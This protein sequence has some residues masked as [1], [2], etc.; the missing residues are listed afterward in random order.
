MRVDLDHLPPIRPVRWIIL[1][2]LC[3]A[4][5]LIIGKFAGNRAADYVATAYDDRPPP[6]RP[7][8]VKNRPATHPT[9]GR[10]V[11]S[12]TIIDDHAGNCAWI[13]IPNN[14][15]VIAPTPTC[16]VNYLE[17]PEDSTQPFHVGNPAKSNQSLTVSNNTFVYVSQH[18]NAQGYR[19]TDL[20]YA[21]KFYN[22]AF[23][24]D[25]ETGFRKLSIDDFAEW[26]VDQSFPLQSQLYNGEIKPFDYSSGSHNKD[27]AP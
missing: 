26:A 6:P 8:F 18:K 11:W 15:V 16:L 17:L 4:T 2:L 3:F 7:W 10:R 25:K 27:M 5:F 13:D 9:E 19:L 14:V 21:D 22:I 1:I 12:P 23:E 24:V 20:T